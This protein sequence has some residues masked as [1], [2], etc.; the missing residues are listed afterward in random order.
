MGSRFKIAIAAPQF[1]IN[2]PQVGS[3]LLLP[4]FVGN[5]HRPRWIAIGSSLFSL[6]TLMCA[7]P[8]ILIPMSQKHRN[9]QEAQYC[10]A[11]STTLLLGCGS[12]NGTSFFP[13]QAPAEDN[14]NVILFPIFFLSLFTIGMGQTAVYTLGIPFLDDNVASRDSPIY[15]CE[16]SSSD[17]SQSSLCPMLPGVSS[18]LARVLSCEI[19]VIITF[20]C[21]CSAAITIGVRILGPV[22]GFI[23]GSFCT[24]LYIYPHITPE[25]EPNDPRW[26]GQWT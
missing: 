5:G 8:H 11:N 7:S 3:A 4:Y 6:A 17:V 20:V 23:I 24:R 10:G 14:P 26:L 21:W 13:D 12:S 22:F 9:T 19:E 2:C 18:L 25:F 15:F 1:L 16:F